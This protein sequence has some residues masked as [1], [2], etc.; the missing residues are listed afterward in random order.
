[1]KSIKIIDKDFNRLAEIDNYTSFEFIK[2]FYR[3]GE[4]ELRINANKL[5]I[6][7]LVKNNIIILG[8]SFD[9]IGVILHREFDK[10]Q[11]DTLVVKGFNLKGII[12]RR[13]IIPDVGQDYATVEGTQ[14]AIM[15]QFVDKNCINSSDKNR[16]I[17]QLILAKNLNR[18]IND[19]W[20]ASYENLADKLQEIGE[21]SKL[22]WDVNLDIKNK[23]FIFDVIQGRDLTVNQNIL[24]PVIFRADFNNIKNRRYTESIINSKNVIYT[25]TR[26]DAEKIV[27]QV[28]E[29]TNFERVETFADYNSDDTNE[30]LTEGNRKLKELSEFKSFE[31]D[32]NPFKPFKYGEDYFLGDK[33]TIQDRKLGVT[34]DANIVEIKEYYNTQG[35]NLNVTFGNTMPSILKRIKKGW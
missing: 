34:M 33:V 17:Q 31:L 1:M 6:E 35:V 15:K 3:V 29:A 7:K 27:L 30:I 11:T 26:E 24:P 4:F 16:T 14:E 19:R 20:R 25:G 28:G 32:I 13:L 12:S 18:G 10:Q 9:K 23:K 5:H 21:Y 22:G 8:N 2:R